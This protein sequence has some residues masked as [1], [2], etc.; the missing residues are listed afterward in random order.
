MMSTIFLA[1]FPSRKRKVYSD[2]Q[3]SWLFFLAASPFCSD[4]IYGSP[5]GIL[6]AT[7][8]SR[9]PWKS[10]KIHNEDDEAPLLPPPPR[11]RRQ[12][13]TEIDPLIDRL[14]WTIADKHLT[15]WSAAERSGIA[16]LAAA[17]ITSLIRKT[18][19]VYRKERR[20]SRSNALKVSLPPEIYPNFN[21][22]ASF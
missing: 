6:T 21:I 16:A 4:V 10:L 11:L 12:A 5:L 7:K 20:G 14:R 15:R 1:P 18:L 17:F 2:F 19:I 8:N 9:I 13:T 22:E 3:H